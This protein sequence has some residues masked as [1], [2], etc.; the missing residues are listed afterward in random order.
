MHIPRISIVFAA[1]VLSAMIVA[2][3]RPALAD[4][5][6]IIVGGVWAFKIT[7]PDGAIMPEQR[8]VEV[9]RA[10]TEVLS[11]YRAG[12]SIPVTL[13]VVAK[14]VAISVGEIHVVTVT[15]ADAQGTGVTPLELARQWSARLSV[16]VARA[17]PDAN[18]HVF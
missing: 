7:Q 1:V 11:K 17:L 13:T 2:I 6:D 16:G 3:P 8:V 12:S 10:L 4:P 15:P 5:Y 9:H 18:V 14:G